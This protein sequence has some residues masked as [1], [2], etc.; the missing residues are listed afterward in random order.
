MPDPTRQFLFIVLAVLILW[1]L[2]SCTAIGVRR[3]YSF[4]GGYGK[5]KGRFSVTLEPSDWDTLHHEG[6]TIIPPK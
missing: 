2:C 1:A 5:A 4:E 6:K 3:T